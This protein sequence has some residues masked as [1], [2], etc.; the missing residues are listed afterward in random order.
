MAHVLLPEG[1]ADFCLA[2]QDIAGFSKRME[3]KFPS[4][5]IQEG[6][7]CE[8]QVFLEVS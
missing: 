2:H 4:L 1:W 8:Q 7:A 6:Y 5:G 3:I